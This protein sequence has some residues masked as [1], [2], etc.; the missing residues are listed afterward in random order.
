MEIHTLFLLIILQIVYRSGD[1]KPHS[2]QHLLT[3]V[4][5]DRSNFTNNANIKN[6]PNNDQIQRSNTT[7][8]ESVDALEKNTLLSELPNVLNYSITHIPREKREI[9]L[10]DIDLM[11]VH[12]PCELDIGKHQMHKIPSPCRISYRSRYISEDH[13][14]SYRL[15]QLEGFTFGQHYERFRRYETEQHTFEYRGTDMFNG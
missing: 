6:F 9:R 10:K 8:N 2:V 15:Y 13:F 4:Q 1:A 5:I 12:H 11:L 14:K 7:K 3:P